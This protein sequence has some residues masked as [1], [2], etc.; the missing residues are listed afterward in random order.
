MQ[1]NIAAKFICAALCTAFLTLGAGCAGKTTYL[2]P[3]ESDV[4]QSSAES[5]S[6][7][8]SAA[9]AKQSSGAQQSS[10]AETQQS[11]EA[12]SQTQQSSAAEQSSAAQQSSATA[13]SEAQ[14]SSDSGSAAQVN[15][16][17]P[18]AMENVP[19]S[20]KA[21]INSKSIDSA[22]EGAKSDSSVSTPGFISTMQNV[23]N[24]SDGRFVVSLLS[25]SDEESEDNETVYTMSK[26]D[27]QN[28]GGAVYIQSAFE[29]NYAEYEL[30]FLQKDGTTYQIDD[31]SKTYFIVGNDDIKSDP[32]REVISLTTKFKTISASGSCKYNG[33]DATF[34]RYEGSGEVLVVYFSGNTVLGGEIYDQSSG[35]LKSVVYANINMGIDSSH[36]SLPTDYKKEG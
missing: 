18:E 23:I 36:T 22:A 3:T 2:T 25:V 31:L 20:D 26:T 10:S 5:S 11:S 19:Q 32:Y 35:K 33:S 16:N 9:A 21:L 17:V 6:A 1:K 7:A 24:G 13:S 27:L 14:Q 28:S 12:A 15:T 30:S 4:A 8:S 29:D 34:E